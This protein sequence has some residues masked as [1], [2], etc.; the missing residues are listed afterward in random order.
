M[1][2]FL[3]LR[4]FSAF[5]LAIATG[6]FLLSMPG[7]FNAGP[8]AAEKR[9]RHLFGHKA[10]PAALKSRAIGFYAR[11]CLAGGTMLPVDGPAWQAMRLSRNR[12]WGHPQMVDLVERLAIESK[13]QD[14][15]PGLLVG[16]LSQPRGGPYAHGPSQPPGWP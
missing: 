2:V 7:I 12:N 10:K 3:K 5:V 1:R 11:G 14:N 6:A 4:R 9:A 15:W 13:E 16:D 8:A